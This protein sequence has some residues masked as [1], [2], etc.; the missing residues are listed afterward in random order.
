MT[1]SEPSDPPEQKVL[2]SSGSEADRKVRDVSIQQ[3]FHQIQLLFPSLIDAVGRLADKHPD[4]ANKFVDD[5]IKQGEHRQTLEE[6][7][8]RGDNQRSTLAQI[9]VS[10]TFVYYGHNTIEI[11]DAFRDW[12][13]CDVCPSG[14]GFRCNFPADWREAITSWLESQVHLGIAGGPLDW[15]RQSALRVLGGM[16]D[17]GAPK[18]K[19]LQESQGGSVCA[20]RPF[21]HRCCG[22]RSSLM[23]ASASCSLALIHSNSGTSPRIM[24]RMAA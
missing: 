16:R 10:E 24:P 18:P 23:A 12:H 11:P 1:L 14:P 15:R 21:V 7:V 5:V 17:S 8:V 22:S 20:R 3:S 13:G 4:I 6:V 9:L 2:P 19:V